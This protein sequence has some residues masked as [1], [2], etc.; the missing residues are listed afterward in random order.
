MDKRIQRTAFYILFLLSF[1]AVHLTAQT[2]KLYMHN[3]SQFVGKLISYQPGDSVKFQLSSGLIVVFPENTVKRIVMGE[4]KVEKAYA[5][6][7]RGFYNATY[8]GMSFGKSQIPW[9]NDSQ[10]KIGASV[11]NNTGYQFNRWLGAGL[12]VGYDNYYLTNIDANVLSIAAELRGYLSKQNNSIYYRVATGA[13]FPLV[14]TK[15]GL[16][17]SGH[18]GGFM[19]HPALGVRFGASAKMNFFMDFGAKFQ[20]VHFNQINP[21]N[22]NRYTI[23]YQRWI[24]RGG[25]MF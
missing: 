8:L 6:R 13:G 7:E 25:F 17:L 16:N 1:S 22:E 3:N 5:F 12:S 24:M 10:L 11:E 2:D 19:C 15:D 4:L 23:T 18:K 14:D 21:W 9:S 20:R